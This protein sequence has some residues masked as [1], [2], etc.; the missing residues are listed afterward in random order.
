MINDL[1]ILNELYNGTCTQNSSS[2]QKSGFFE[3][4]KSIDNIHPFC[5]Q[6]FKH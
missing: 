2:Q 4:C 5:N 1:M 3:I 6:D